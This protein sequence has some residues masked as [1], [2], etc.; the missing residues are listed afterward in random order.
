M[1]LLIKKCLKKKQGYYS[2]AAPCITPKNQM[3]TFFMTGFLSF[4]TSKKLKALYLLMDKQLL[5]V[6]IILSNINVDQMFK[7]IIFYFLF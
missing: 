5:P 4:S 3:K 2:K 1:T 6:I 7:K